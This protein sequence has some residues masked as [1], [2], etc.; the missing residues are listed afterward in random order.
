M[1]KHS[2]VGRSTMSKPAPLFACLYARE[3][4]AQA[5]LRSRHELRNSPCIVLDGEPPLQQ[6]CSLNSKA[7]AIGLAHGM[8]CVEVETFSAITTL[9]RSRT[10]EGTARSALLECVAFFSPR[11]EDRST[12][13]AFLCILDISGTKKLFGSPSRLA[14]TCSAGCDS[15]ASAPQ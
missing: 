7:R 15:C 5:L 9:I 2:V 14:R 4:P 12:E 11:I 3:F 6:L 1:G 8:T 13:N 10:E